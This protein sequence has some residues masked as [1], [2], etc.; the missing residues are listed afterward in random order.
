MRSAV[1][2]LET[3]PPK[4]PPTTSPTESPDSAGRSQ[5]WR[6][7]EGGLLGLRAQGDSQSSELSHRVP[8]ST[9]QYKRGASTR[10]PTPRSPHLFP[11]H[12]TASA[13]RVLPS[14]EPHPDR[15]LRF[16]AAH[17]CAA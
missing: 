9:R 13:L 6:H 2:I 17:A 1:A 7:R 11:Y 12:R 14:R 15:A 16:P 4:T 5:G 10:P 8:I 3:G